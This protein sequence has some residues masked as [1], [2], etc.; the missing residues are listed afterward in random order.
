LNTIALAFAG[1]R[2]ALFAEEVAWQKQIEAVA[3][4]WGL[5]NIMATT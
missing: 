1:A 3:T 2:T 5:L 4:H